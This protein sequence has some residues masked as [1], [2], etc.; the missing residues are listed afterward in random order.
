MEKDKIAELARAFA[1]GDKDAFG[2]LYEIYVKPIYN[3]IY[4]KTHH[5]ESAEEITSEVFLKAYKSAADYNS[6]KGT[7]QAWIYKIARNS[8]IDHY[9]AARPSLNIDDAWDLG[10]NEDILKDVEN[11]IILKKV[12]DYISKLPLSQRDIII[13]RIW[14]GLSYDEISE[15]V[16]KSEANC[17]MIFSRAINKLRSSIPE[18][19][20]VIALSLILKN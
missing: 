9:R 5:R 14:Q 10:S 3:F 18:A 6:A 11:K 4:Y 12:Q 19:T 15:I 8:V 20:L 7:F 2:K 13:M 1:E 16:G 17:K